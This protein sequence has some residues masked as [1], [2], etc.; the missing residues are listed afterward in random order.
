MDVGL[1]KGIFDKQKQLVALTEKAGHQ[2]VAGNMDV[3]GCAGHLARNPRRARRLIPHGGR[4]SMIERWTPSL[5]PPF[6]SC[7][8]PPALPIPPDLARDSAHSIVT[9]ART[10]R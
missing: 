9:E 2:V 4:S 5:I 10:Q 1:G 3:D 6:A 7:L 8:T